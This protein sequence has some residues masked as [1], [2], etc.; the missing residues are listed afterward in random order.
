MKANSGQ[1][2]Y[3][4]NNAVSIANPY[5]HNVNVV[6]HHFLYMCWKIRIVTSR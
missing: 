5:N 4:A 6:M 2:T 1:S 3:P